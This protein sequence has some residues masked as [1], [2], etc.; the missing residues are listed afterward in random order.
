MEKVS[1]NDFLTFDYNQKLETST[2]SMP[3]FESVC[4]K[5]LLF[6]ATLHEMVFF[7]L[8]SD[9]CEI[10]SLEDFSC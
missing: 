5:N 6:T 7:M 2:C 4:F 10:S 9:R 8:V 3:D 1:R